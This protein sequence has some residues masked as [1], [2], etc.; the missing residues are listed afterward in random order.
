MS[1]GTMLTIG[2]LVFVCVL[3][4]AVGVWLDRVLT[5]RWREDADRQEG[6]R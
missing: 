3:A 4:L 6:S 5:R 2:L 1:T